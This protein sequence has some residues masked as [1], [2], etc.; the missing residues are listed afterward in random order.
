ML[1]VVTVKSSVIFLLTLG[2]S[3]LVRTPPAPVASGSAAGLTKGRPKPNRV[4]LGYSHGDNDA[5]W[6]PENYDYREMTHIARCCLAVSRDG[7]ITTGKIFDTK[8]M[9]RARSNGVKLLASLG[10]WTGEDGYKP[11]LEMTGNAKATQRFLNE[12]DKLVREQG[13]DGVDIDWEPLAPDGMADRDLAELH[14]EYTGLLAALRARFPKWIITTAIGIGPR[15]FE[16][17]DWQKIKDNVDF[18]NLMAYDLSGSWSTH[19]AHNANLYPTK[20]STGD[21][22]INT[23]VTALLKMH[24]ALRAKLLLGLPFFGKEFPTDEMG[25]GPPPNPLFWGRSIL[26]AD[27]APLAAGDDYKTLWDDN[28]HASYLVKNGG[29]GTITFDDERVIA[30]K[31]RYVKQEGLAGVSIWALGQDFY[32]GHPVLL[33]VIANE[34]GAPFAGRSHDAW[35]NPR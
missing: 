3:G 2:T 4:I 29:G 27:I 25:Q 35:P 17:M 28:A 24:Y 26:Y 34:M 8:L 21:L 12:L 19:A 7:G 5:R 13:Y 11:W 6:E 9:Q 20:L 1:R 10:G 18:V 14:K 22:D 30:D 23:S 15:N 16:L 33:D 32:R 31:C